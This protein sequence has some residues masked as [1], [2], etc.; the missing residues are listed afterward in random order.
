MTNAK[1]IY[2]YLE[3]T[4][5]T[6]W[7]E[8]A[9]LLLR[10]NMKNHLVTSAKFDL[11]WSLHIWHFCFSQNTGEKRKK[12]GWR[13]KENCCSRNTHFKFWSKCDVKVS[14]TLYYLVKMDHFNVVIQYQHF[15]FFFIQTK[16]HLHI[17]IYHAE[18]SRFAKFHKNP[19]QAQR[20]MRS[21]TCQILQRHDFHFFINF[22]LEWKNWKSVH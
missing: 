2:F 18:F 12:L 17:L 20:K 8:T 10:G 3:N 21:Q 13:R 16:N 4:L 9:C 15:F 22:F 1:H 14:F 7:L 19:L 6:R 5:N 11:T